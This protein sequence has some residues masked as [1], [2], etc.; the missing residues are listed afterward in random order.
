MVINEIVL[1]LIVIIVN[2]TRHNCMRFKIMRVVLGVHKQKKKKVLQTAVRLHRIKLRIPVFGKT[3]HTGYTVPARSVC[4]K[5]RDDVRRACGSFNISIWTLNGECR[6]HSGPESTMKIW[7]NFT[8]ILRLDP[9]SR[10][11]TPCVV[12]YGMH[13]TGKK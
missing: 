6:F 7:L 13:W 5:V 8:E 12:R 1:F 10:T 9:S 2:Y 4:G 3:Y 11:I